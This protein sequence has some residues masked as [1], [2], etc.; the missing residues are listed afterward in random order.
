[1]TASTGGVGK[2]TYP[3]AARLKVILCAMVNAVIV[4]I[5]LHL[6]FVISISTNNR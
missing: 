6:P 4:L 1:M 5:I 2:F 3:K